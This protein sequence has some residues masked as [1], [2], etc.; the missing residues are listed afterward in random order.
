M[1]G[2]AAAPTA[3]WVVAFSVFVLGLRHGADPD[4]LAAIDNLT[5]NSLSVR[6]RLS[7][8]VGALFAGGH[9]VMVLAIAALAGI[10]GSH[11]AV[12]GAL[13]ESIGTWVSIVTLFAIAA[14]NVRQLAL[15]RVGAI[16]GFKSAMLPKALR[17]AT[18]P[19]AAIPVGLIFGLGF[20][21]SS[22]V[23]TYALALT[24]GGGVVLGLLI[25][26][27]FSLG[28]SVTD[29]LD[30]LLVYK[31]CTRHPLELVRA[32]RVWIIAVT[33]LALAVGSYELAQALGWRSPVPDLTVSG[34]LVG[35]LFL[36]F[37]W[38]FTWSARTPHTAGLE[39][40]GQNG[41]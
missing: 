1:I 22:Q 10:L 35:A 8:F 4:H 9:S 17:A 41:V 40:N 24:A 3:F 25:G 23:A 5:R 12:H 6:D 2:H 11:I 38:T 30:S 39:Y 33:T 29:T 21:T 31:L 27:F 26:L 34:I 13:L 32:T 19:L 18:N 37:A 28:M 7:R 16:A 14:L 36:V 15:N 20:D